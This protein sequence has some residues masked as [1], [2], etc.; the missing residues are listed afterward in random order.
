MSG[1]KQREQAVLS[2]IPQRW[3]LMLVRPYITHAPV[4]LPIFVQI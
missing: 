1:M 2:Q 3:I 4:T